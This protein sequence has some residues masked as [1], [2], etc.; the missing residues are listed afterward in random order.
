M[1]V[2]P[3]AGQVHHFLF[4][5]YAPVATD[6]SQ[7]GNWKGFTMFE[8]LFGNLFWDIDLRRRVHAIYQKITIAHETGIIDISIDNEC[9]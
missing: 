2:A 8:F 4:R 7:G 6:R 5:L 9:L 3:P 1:N